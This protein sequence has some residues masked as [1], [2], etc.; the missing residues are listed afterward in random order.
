MKHFLTSALGVVG[1]AIA[2]AF[3]GWGAG[4]TTLLIFMAIDYITGLLVAGVFHASKK[5]ESGRLDSRAGFKGLIRKGM[6]L[7]IVLIAARLDI[8]LNTTFVR[9]AVVIAFCANEA[10]SIVEN[11]GLMGVP[12]PA[13]LRRAIEALEAKGNE[14]GEDE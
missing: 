3:G 7:L 9:D 8:L 6:V 2:A 5:S 13:S 10:I 1:G 12:I 11:A 14:D 4:L